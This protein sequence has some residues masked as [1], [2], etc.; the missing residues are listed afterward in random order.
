M[1]PCYAYGVCAGAY[2]TVSRVQPPAMSPSHTETLKHF[3]TGR[4]SS[5]VI[6]AGS[7][8]WHPRPR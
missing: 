4:G 2:D 7:L 8:G 6:A 1:N 5:V 3:T